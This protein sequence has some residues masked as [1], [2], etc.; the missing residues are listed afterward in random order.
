MK[1]FGFDLEKTTF[2]HYDVLKTRTDGF[3]EHSLWDQYVL[4]KN[5]VSYYMNNQIGDQWTFAFAQESSENDFNID[6]WGTEDFVRRSDSL[7][8]DLV[9]DDDFFLNLGFSPEFM[10]IIAY[11][12]RD[13]HIA[14]AYVDLESSKMVINLDFDYE[15]YDDYSNSNVSYRYIQ[16]IE[17]S[18]TD[19]GST[20]T[21]FPIDDLKATACTVLDEEMISKAEYSYATAESLNDLQTLITTYKNNINAGVTVDQ[22]AG[23]LTEYT[24]AISAYPLIIDQLKKLKIDT[25]ILMRNILNEL[26]PTATPDSKLAMQ[27]TFDNYSMM[28]NACILDTDVSE[29]FSLYE[30]D[31]NDA[32]V[33]DELLIIG[34]IK[35][36]AR[37]TLS[38]FISQNGYLLINPDDSLPYWNVY[39]LYE[40]Q[41]NE[42]QSVAQVNNLF[43]SAC[44]ELMNLNYPYDPIAFR[45]YQVQMIYELKDL[46]IVYTREFGSYSQPVIDAWDQYWMG[47]ETSHNAIEIGKMK[48][49]AFKAVNSIFLPETK[50]LILDQLEDLYNQYCSWVSTDLLDDLTDDY[51]L[52]QQQV[53]DETELSYLLS[54]I[55]YSAINWDSFVSDPI[56]QSIYQ[57]IEQLQQDFLN[58]S[59]MATT[60]SITDMET[61]MNDQIAIL[62][63][64]ADEL[65]LEDSYNH[66]LSLLNQAFCEDSDKVAVKDHITSLKTKA[67]QDFTYAMDFLV[68]SSEVL[69][70]DERYDILCDA[71]EKT[72]SIDAAD[73]LYNNWVSEMLITTNAWNNEAINQKEVSLLYQ[74]DNRYESLTTA[75]TSPVDFNAQYN[76][77]LNNMSLEENLIKYHNL[78]LE[79]LE[80]L[81]TSELWLAKEYA[82]LEIIDD[83]QYY[84]SVIIDGELS[85][86]ES[87]YKNII[88][89]IDDLV[90]VEMVLNDLNYFRQEC[91]SYTQDQVKIDILY[92]KN[93]LQN[94]FDDLA[95]TAT[96]ESIL[97]MQMTMGTNIPLIEA[98][99]TSTEVLETFNDAYSQLYDKYVQVNP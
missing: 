50:I 94:T 81:N 23:L 31:V 8:F 86:L 88:D 78:Y 84:H 7:I 35:T 74:L 38:E 91:Y 90:S 45:N 59:G 48:Y 95:Q 32:Y 82:K 24:S 22:I 30:D 63:D 61:V 53:N 72:L 28:V 99:T 71:L 17:Y 55:G 96:A 93:Q 25:V 33:F 70:F 21:Q 19:I 58:Y 29:K 37:F 56:R 67:Y 16:N 64:S 73:T 44:Q 46:H 92:Y 20:A 51:V 12:F 83:Y 57:T 75:Y 40:A 62:N 69:I 6:I 14:K 9:I 4:F 43:L 54:F 39:N 5:N 27:S 60:E 66:A 77:Y 34:S 80:Y 87:L 2:N 13:Y 68:Y 41:I 11:Y 42:A 97:A 47:M 89:S 26:M 15:W 1:V 76:L 79:C 10:P 49:D 65:E 52:K 85:S 36:D 98:C 18:F 3:S